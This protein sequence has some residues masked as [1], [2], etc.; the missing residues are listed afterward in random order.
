MHH[1]KYKEAKIKQK[2]YQDEGFKLPNM[3]TSANTQN[4]TLMQK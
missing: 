1:A 3:T 2:Q 4:T